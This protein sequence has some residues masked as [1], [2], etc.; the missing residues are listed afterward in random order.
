MT[1]YSFSDADLDT[2]TSVSDQL[3][4]MAEQFGI[5]PSVL[6]MAAR[7]VARRLVEKAGSP[8]AAAA[9]LTGEQVT[10]ALREHDQKMREIG[11]R[12]LKNLP[13]T[14]A[15]VYHM[16]RAADHAQKMIHHGN[17]I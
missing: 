13:D 8:E 7:G 17:C 10:A 15:Q 5:D 9:S 16:L 1:T 12:M 11:E 3:D 6:R 2:T 4:A 14:A